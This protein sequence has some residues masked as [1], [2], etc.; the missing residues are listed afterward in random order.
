MAAVIERAEG[1]EHDS[2]AL[3]LVAFQRKAVALGLAMLERAEVCFAV[4]ALA[5]AE[6]W[7]GR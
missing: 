1:Q 2:P 3:E 4:A 7:V 5:G 6:R